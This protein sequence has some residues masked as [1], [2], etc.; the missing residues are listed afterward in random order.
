MRIIDISRELL[1]AKVYP[2]DPVPKHSFVEKMENG[3]DYNLS[4]LF[5]CSHAAT[6][7]DAPLHFIE[8]GKTTEE[9]DM[10]A[11]FGACTV[12]TLPRREVTGAD[13]DEIYPRGCRRILLRTNNVAKL[14]KSAAQVIADNK[15]LLVG[16]DCASIGSGED[17]TAIHRILLG[18]GIA[19]LE[20]L[21][22][23]D[24]PD[25]RYFLCAA[26]IKIEGSEAAPVRAVL[27][28]NAIYTET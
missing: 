23:Y 25:G 6:H 1:S 12:L 22:L 20:G 18:E 24:A 13:I 7:C 4:A 26:P 9:L 28:Q 11:F 10:K 21:D 27:L 8:D 3:K 16:I 15:P 14:T 17:N 19:V 5:C 2:G